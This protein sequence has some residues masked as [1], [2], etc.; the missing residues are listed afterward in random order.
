MVLTTLLTK[1]LEAYLESNL[2]TKIEA[3]A[4]ATSESIDTIKLWRIGYVNPFKLSRYNALMVFQGVA[5]EAGTNAFAAARAE[6]TILQPYNIIAA[7][8]GADA[9]EVTIAQSAYFDAVFNLI[10]DDPTLGGICFESA[11]KD[12]M[13]FVP[14]ER[15]GA[16]GVIHIVANIEIDTLLA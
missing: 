8:S 1:Q 14:E 5:S 11:I 3:V 10:D 2:N 7:I 12:Y 4:A 9:E 6:K 13:P 15:S 16:I